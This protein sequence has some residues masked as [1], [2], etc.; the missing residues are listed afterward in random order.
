MGWH[1]DLLMF[2]E[3]HC[4]YMVQNTEGSLFKFMIY[5]G[6]EVLASPGI[7]SDEQ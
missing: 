6:Y 7:C 4:I 1:F 3:L 2:S 5:V